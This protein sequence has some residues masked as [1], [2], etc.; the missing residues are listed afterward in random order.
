[1]A[2]FWS[3]N[4]FYFICFVLF[5]SIGL[6]TTRETFNSYYST[7]LVLNSISLRFDWKV[8][9]NFFLWFER[10]GKMAILAKRDFNSWRRQNVFVISHDGLPKRRYPRMIWLMPMK[11]LAITQFRTW[12]AKTVA[13]SIGE[14]K[15]PIKAVEFRFDK[16]QMKKETR[17]EGE[18]K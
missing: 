4:L 6:S 14:R 18:A 7:V 5:N 2:D 13:N 11:S 1:M 15:D 9:A 17:E 8:G 3:F 10:T 12:T 16:W